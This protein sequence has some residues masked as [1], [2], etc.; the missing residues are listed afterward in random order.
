M[1]TRD[2][3]ETKHLCLSLDDLRLGFGKKDNEISFSFTFL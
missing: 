1:Q 2:T 3:P